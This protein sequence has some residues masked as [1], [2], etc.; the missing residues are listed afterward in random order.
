MGSTYSSLPSYRCFQHHVPSIR[1]GKHD[2]LRCYRLHFRKG[3]KADEHHHLEC[4]DAKD[5][6][7]HGCRGCSLNVWLHNAECAP[8]SACFLVYAWGIAGSFI[9]G[10]CSDSLLRSRN[11]DQLGQWRVCTD[12]HPAIYGFSCGFLR[13]NAY[14]NPDTRLVAAQ[15]CHTFGDGS[16]R[17]CAELNVHRWDDAYPVLCR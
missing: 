8:Q 3:H 7:C 2:L 15:G 13:R 4:K 14:N 17:S 5:C 6:C 10:C 12:N 11:T 16:C 9:R 1:I